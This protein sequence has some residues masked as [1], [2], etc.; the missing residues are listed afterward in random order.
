MKL[1]MT[2]HDCTQLYTYLNLSRVIKGFPTRGKSVSHA[3]DTATHRSVFVRRLLASLAL[4]LALGSSTAWAQT[5][6][7]GEYYLANNNQDNYAGINHADNYYLCPA[8]EYY[9]GSTMT[10]TDN[11]KPFL[12][13]YKTLEGDNSLWIIQK[14]DGQEY[15]TIKH[16]ASNKYLTVNNALSGYGKTN[17]KRVH[18]EDVAS[19]TDRNYFTIEY[20]NKKSGVIS[21][22]TIGCLDAYKS[23]NNQY[24][25]PANGNFNFLTSQGSENPKSGGLVGFWEKGRATGDYRGSVW[26]FEI[27]K[28]SITLTDATTVTISYPF[29]NTVTIYYTTNGTTPTTSS[30]VYSDPIT[31]STETVFKAIAVLADGT[32]SAV[33]TLTLADFTY[34]ILDTHGNVAIQHTVQQP[35]GKALT[36]YSDIPAAIRSPYIADETVRFF[37]DSGH[38]TEIF[39]TPGSNA[40]IYV[41][42]TTSNLGNKFLHLDDG[43]LLN[44][45]VNG[46]YIFDNSGTLSHEA[47]EDNLAN[48]DRMWR[49]KGEDP[50]AVVIQNVSTGKCF[51]YETSA[52]P[53]TLSLTVEGSASH[54]IIM[55]GSGT[56]KSLAEGQMELMPATGENVTSNTYYRVGRTNDPDV[57]NITTTSGTAAQQIQ[58]V[59]AKA[60]VTYYLID[61]AG[62]KDPGGAIFAYIISTESAVELPAEWQSPLVSAYHYYKT[63]TWN[64]ETLKWDFSDPVTS[65]LEA[66]DIYVTY[67]VN[68]LV[69]FDDTDDDTNGSTTYM[70]EFTDGS[71]FKQEDGDNGVMNTTQKAVYPYANGDGCLNVYGS[72]QWSAQIS[73]GAST[74]TRW[75]WYVVSPNKDPYHV[76]IMSRSGVVNSHNYFRTYVVNYGG[77]NH[78]V[79]GVTTKHADAVAAEEDPTEYMVLKTAAGKCKL[80]TK[81]KIDDGSTDERR[82]VTSFEQYWKTYETV[83]NWGEY[84]YAPPVDNPAFNGITLNYYEARA[85]G[86][87][88]NTSDP[89]VQNSKTYEKVNHF[90]QT[91]NMGSEG[92][93]TFQATTLV[94]QVI[95]LDQHG[96]EIMRQPLYSDDACTT[97]NT[98]ALKHFDSPMVESYHWYPSASVQHGYHKFTV[99]DPAIS[100]QS[101]TPPLPSMKK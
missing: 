10:T 19:L 43:R 54:F 45:T 3:W 50:Y 21:G 65:T 99:S 86:R 13:T 66:S 85:N 36:G 25:N 84:H 77:S 70:L 39:E 95:L 16:K 37:S 7:S 81:D 51:H 2:S 63:K 48:T 31:F 22:Y 94:P 24:L 67:D 60:S 42:Y 41:T 17:R 80:V 55:N 34:K 12:T 40:D 82:T 23:G 1:D 52:L 78:V 73:S 100:T 8:N 30:S 53:A 98:A 28:P 32:Q 5:D 92:E 71:F 101:V 97:V 11:G 61:Q 56:P 64:A 59:S 33:T 88:I 74:R 44:V 27:P 46:E 72:Q 79:T 68:N 96:W 83:S 91:I 15:Y 20:I 9:D 58:A 26:F 57:F 62:M 38:S 35:V 69:S 87:P 49:I 93:F 76:K 29:D 89:T 14:V 47:T 90:F 75:L 18:L 6:Y 4:L